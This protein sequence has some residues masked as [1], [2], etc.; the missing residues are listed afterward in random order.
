MKKILF[1]IF[2]CLGFL[3]SKERLVVLD[4]AAVEI[5]YMLNAQDQIKAIASLKHSNIYP[6]EKTSKLASVGTFSNPSLEKIV[7]LKPSLVILSSYSLGLKENLDNLNIKSLYLKAQNLDDIKENVKVLSKIVS[8]EE[9]GKALI[10]QYE[11]DLEKLRENKTN[12]K[13]IFLYSANPLMAFTKDSPI[14]DIFEILGIKNLEFDTNI[15]RPIISNEFILKNDPD[16]II[17][18]ISANDVNELIKLNP[19]IKHTKA[20]KNNQIYFYKNTHILLR[21]SPMITKRIQD[22]KDDIKLK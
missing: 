17:L 10:Q 4:P 5:I 2:A 3:Y 19:F 14:Y 16:M 21:L 22:F 6:Q 11:K 18:G 13:G 1:L 12:K 9:E 8:K 15:K 7:S 20:Y